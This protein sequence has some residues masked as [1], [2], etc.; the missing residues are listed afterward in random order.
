[1]K[2]E[3]YGFCMVRRPL[4]SRDILEDFHAKTA[5]D[6]LRFESELRRVFSDPM[7]LEGLALASGPLYELTKALLDN[8]PVS[9]K[10][11]LLTSLYKFLVRACSRCTPFGLFAGYFTVETGPDTQISF[12]KLNTI[13][14][15]NRLD[16]TA[17]EAIKA[18]ILEKSA[19]S[20]QLLYYPNSSL[21]R[22]GENYRYIKR[23]QQN[24]HTTFILTE[25]NFH[26]A[27][28][29]LLSESK[30][31]LL[32]EQISKF[33]CQQSQSVANAQAY[34]KALTAAQ[35]LVSSIEL[36][37]TGQ[38]YLSY[39]STTLSALKGTK[40]LTRQIKN[41]QNQLDQNASA[42]EINASLKSFLKAD[43]PLESTLQ[44]TLKFQTDTAHISRKVLS[45]LGSLLSR[46]SPLARQTK[47]EV[48]EDFTRRFVARYG[49]Q[50]IP[51]LLA[52][53]YDYGAG[54][55]EL[56]SE[57]QPELPLLQAIDPDK[58]PLKAEDTQTNEL[59]DTLYQQAFSKADR[60]VMLTDTLLKQRENTNIQQLPPSFYVLGSFH[61][62]SV[63]ALD[64][65][66]FLFELKGLAGPLA[67]NL[68][69]RFCEGDPELSTQVQTLINTEESRDDNVIYAEIVHH[70]GGKGS[71]VAARPAHRA[72]EIAYLAKSLKENGNSISPDDLW[73]SCPDGENLILSAPKLSKQIIPV[74][75]SAH[76]YSAGLPVY[77]FLC[78]LAN[79][80]SISLV[81]D[82]GS[83]QNAPFLPRVQHQQLV[84]SKASWL[85]S[86]AP[87][88]PTTQSK[89]AWWKEIERKLSTPQY[90]TTGDGDQTLLFDSKN[91]HSLS[92]LA[93][94]LKNAGSLRITESLDTPGEG[95]LTHN[96]KY[97]SNEFVIPFH[98]ANRTTPFRVNQKQKHS[99]E[100]ITRSFTAG[101]QW[102]YFKIYC[103][104]RLSDSL[105]TTVLNPFLQTLQKQKVIEK[106]FFIRYRD[107]EPHI[108]LRFYSEKK[109]FW[110]IVFKELHELLSPLLQNGMVR[111]V[112]TDTYQRELERYP[113]KVYTRLES[114][115]HSDSRAV[116][117]CLMH[118]SQ[119]AGLR[120][121]AAL[122]GTDLMLD[123]L[124]LDLT[125]KSDLIEA[126][127]RQFSAELDVDG[128][129]RRQMDQNYRAEKK[130]ISQILDKQT[131]PLH[132]SM[133]TLFCRRTKRIQALILHSDLTDSALQTRL[134]CDLIHL[135]LNRW[136]ASRQR[137][138]EFAVYH[139]LKKYYTSVL[140]TNKI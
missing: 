28:E 70:P 11:K 114:I 98:S 137:Q 34:V 89:T 74:I 99:E 104:E 91:E 53:D 133:S 95:L 14:R 56:S 12:E 26:K 3:S 124:G 37:V 132:K 19:L 43:H 54:Y 118:F 97:L 117:N 47:S 140:K 94:M 5:N 115:F 39:L 60:Q 109:D 79:Q 61:S 119:D 48:L 135:F 126:M 35:I 16:A 69:T 4:L 51:L 44:T 40:T 110:M 32:A 108:R 123:S 22:A 121:Q 131:T 46:I 83:Y 13:R 125:G 15:N 120:W 107:P 25:A 136:F 77:R 18:H 52:L 139:Y 116:V 92:L 31:G 75:T 87:A 2:L 27:L 33:L 29:K 103:G 36:N 7:L 8:A 50:R 62:R 67:C 57:T 41:I 64:D 78:D 105:L 17:L 130:T 20:C 45:R 30:N 106:W 134:G 72:Y 65:G 63:Q 9:G 138:Q 93:Q 66:E 1:M 84:L 23:Q 90:F 82:W 86:H 73:L 58:L 96:E 113:Q 88:A 101:S 49:Q 59:A 85:L 129:V 21:Y 24:G 112:H 80:K 81:W 100:K 10:E 71:N 42:S 68:L 55:G 76:H 6:P 122:V 102:L 127:H 111:S 128:S 38:D